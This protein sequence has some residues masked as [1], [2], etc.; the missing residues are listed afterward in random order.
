MSLLTYGRRIYLANV[1][2]SRAIIARAGSLPSSEIASDALTNDHKPDDKDEAAVIVANNGRID[3]YRDA[4]GNPLG[5]LRVWL[6]NE[7][8]PGLA[9][10]RSFGDQVAARVGVNA[11]PE[12]GELDLNKDDKFIVLASD[13]IWEFLK[14]IDVARIIYP[15]Y[16]KKNAEGAAESLVREAF[17]RWKKE[18]DVID[19]ITC[20]VIFLDVKQQVTPQPSS[21]SSQANANNNNSASGQQA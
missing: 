9:M 14:N 17:K 2:D 15:F 6:K 21:T 12:L 20:I 3:S 19:D 13:G 1:G 10:T 7:D 5:P 16:L 4:N 11:V 8:I 18:E